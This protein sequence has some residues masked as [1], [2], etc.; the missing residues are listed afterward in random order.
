MSHTA[1]YLGLIQ[2]KLGCFSCSLV[3][4][5]SLCIIFLLTFVTRPIIHKKQKIFSK[6]PSLG[7][8][9]LYKHVNWQEQR[10]WLAVVLQNSDTM[11]VWGNKQKVKAW[12]C[13]LCMC[14]SHMFWG[15][16]VA[17]PTSGSNFRTC[18][19]VK[20]CTIGL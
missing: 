8:I 15:L 14:S 13:L 9:P 7:P 18:T 2:P 5:R 3:S 16:Q 17:C 10:F 20:E 19:L 4:S 11:P 6:K 1:K 12:T